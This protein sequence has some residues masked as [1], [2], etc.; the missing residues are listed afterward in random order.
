MQIIKKDFTL[1]NI[2]K[3]AKKLALAITSMLLIIASM[4]TFLVK[5]N[6]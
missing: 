6:F 4:N 3:R 1:I 2:E 5:N